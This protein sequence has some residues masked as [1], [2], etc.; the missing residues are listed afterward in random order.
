LIAEA[1]YILNNPALEAGK[2]YCTLTWK[3]Y[4]KAIDK[5]KIDQGQ[6]G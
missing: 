4:K 2:K 1:M 3:T 5:R 6:S